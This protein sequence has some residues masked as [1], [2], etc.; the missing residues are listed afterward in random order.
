GLIH[1]FDPKQVIEHKKSGELGVIIGFNPRKYKT[2][3]VKW[4]VGK[5]NKWDHMKGEAYEDDIKKSDKPNPIDIP[6]WEKYPGP[7]SRLIAKMKEAEAK[8][9]EEEKTSKDIDK[10][11]ESIE[12][13]L[14][15]KRYNNI[16]DSFSNDDDDDNLNF[17]NEELDE[18]INDDDLYNSIKDE[19][20]FD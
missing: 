12:E 14:K 18:D 8:R 3:T 5:P 16:N 2:Y 20:N 4:H 19:L 10:L 1:K 6:S 13:D 7:S 17:E 9:K 11:H 15:R